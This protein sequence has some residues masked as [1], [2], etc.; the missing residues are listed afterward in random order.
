MPTPGIGTR[1]LKLEIDGTD[2]TA[3]VATVKI[4][5]AESDADFLSFEAASQGGAR[6]YAL[7]LVLVQSLATNSLYRKILDSS[8]EEVDFVIRPY[9]GT[10]PSV[11]QPH[12]TGSV[13]ISE[14]DGDLFGGDSATSTT[15][16]F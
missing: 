1:S 4:T 14:P 6:D 3:S 15:A 12:V 16:R 9:G 13:I 2:F 7:N 11:G 10:T 5:S 8:G